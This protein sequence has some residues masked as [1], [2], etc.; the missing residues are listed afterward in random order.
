[1]SL[2]ALGRIERASFG[3]YCSDV[4]RRSSSRR[5]GVT[6]RG[7]AVG[8][9][10]K[11]RRCEGEKSLP[12]RASRQSRVPV[13]Y[14]Q[15]RR[16][17][18]Y[19]GQKSHNRSRW[20]QASAS[21]SRTWGATILELAGHWAAVSSSPRISTRR[22]LRRR[23]GRESVPRPLSAETR[24]GRR[25]RPRRENRP[26]PSPTLSFVA[27]PLACSAAKNAPNRARPCY[28]GAVPGPMLISRGL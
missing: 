4:T 12:W 9:S 15:R 26:R 19:R 1:M 7:G 8:A 13:P 22:G 14:P 21:V 10:L 20:L 28:P 16:R 25:A 23:S 11:A 3:D 6:I 2:A 17:C 18:R 27:C 24:C 5:N